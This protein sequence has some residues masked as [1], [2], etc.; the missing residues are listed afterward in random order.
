[1][2]QR[3][4][5]KVAVITGGGNGIGRGVAM[6]MAAEGAKVVVSDF[7][8][9]KDGS[10]AADNVVEEIVKANGTAVACY[11]SV[12]TMQGGQNIVGTAISNFDRVD[13]LV[14]CA[15]NFKAAS[16]VDFTEQMWDSIMDVHLR[17]H[18]NCIKAAAPEMM[19][20]KGGRIINISSRAASGGSGSAAYS[21]A[22][23]GILGLTSSLAMELQQHGITVNAITPSAD[24]KLF[25]GKRVVGWD[26]MPVSKWIGPEYVAPIIV[27]LAT[28]EAQYINGRYIFASGGDICFY[29]QPMQIPGSAPMFVRKM[30]MWTID[31]LSEAIPSIA[32]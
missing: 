17:G 30:G 3:L 12:T 18:F 4:S 6:A 19:K 7:A 15:G 22:K 20:Q 11:D 27:Y 1:M 14:N 31:E 24:T 9:E 2:T 5:G 25:P 13:I 32:G 16:I 8:S 21:A 28:D 10:R 23:A 29:P 26:N